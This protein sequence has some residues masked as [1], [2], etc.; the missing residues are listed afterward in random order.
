MGSIKKLD[1]KLINLIAAGE[2]VER[3][4]SVIKEL[5]ENS[6][7]AKATKIVTRFKEY[8][9]KL[10]E[11]ID[12]GVGIEKE[13]LPL[14]IK[15]H[16]TSKLSTEQDLFNISTFGFRGEALAS[17]SEVSEEIL[18]TTK[19]SSDP[20]TY[21]LH[22]TPQ[23]VKIEETISHTGNGTTIKV[24]NLFKNI[25][26]RLKFLKS[27]NTETNSI[28]ETFISIAIPFQNIH[29]EIYNDEK[30]VYK[31][32]KTGNILDRILQIYGKEVAN[33]L[34]IS[35][36]LSQE[37]YNIQV[38]AS[39]PESCKK[40][41]NFQKIY[42]NNRFITDKTIHSAIINSFK[43]FIHK[44]L[45]PNYVVLINTNKPNLVDVNVHPRKIEARFKEQQTVY[46]IVSE[47]TNKILNEYTKSVVYNRIFF[48][49]N[50]ESN[51]ETKNI[52][53]INYDISYNSSFD[54]I[55]HEEHLSN[56][57]NINVKNVHNN[58]NEITY[59][60]EYINNKVVLKPL[61][62]TSNHLL[63]QIINDPT[64]NN[65]EH[66]L[67][68]NE[69]GSTLSQ[70]FENQPTKPDATDET[71]TQM[72]SNQDQIDENSIIQIFFSYILYERDNKIIII[73][74]HAA[75]EKITFEKLLKSYTKSKTKRLLLPKI[76]QLK[77][78]YEKEYLLSYKEILENIGIKIEEFSITDIMITEIPELLNSESPIEELLMSILNN[79]Y[80]DTLN[81]QAIYKHA[82]DSLKIDQKSYSILATLACHSSIRANMKLSK[83]E[84]L[85]IIRNLQNLEFPYSCPHGR[86]I[87]I[88]ITKYEIDKLFKRKI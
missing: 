62:S 22:K 55:I 69:Y 83:A 6:I 46:T 49:K 7:D 85:Y 51:A 80:V 18:I 87:S 59:S 81:D 43:F 21:K 88:E 28:I 74:Q 70:V 38:I 44:D 52:Q 23:E 56:K 41:P 15:Q 35:P 1:Q 53:K 36:F 3:P 24:I 39:T 9:I 45:K 58:N 2:V 29:F 19:T 10:I 75:S 86:P 84:M 47:L 14:T 61:T 32:S 76:V 63:D 30:L 11:V 8:G 17:I 4:S 57:Q 33:N 54:T 65:I 5:I 68:Y 37:S 73:D 40:T 66:G 67:T 27:P 82:I 71:S 13:D 78:K 48:Q 25:P 77:N 42:V 64:D 72:L 31:L 20:T 60:N 50:Y 12:N 79:Q 16:T 26:A 34:I